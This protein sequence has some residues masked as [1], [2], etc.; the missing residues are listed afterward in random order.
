LSLLEFKPSAVKI[1]GSIR[2]S[3]ELAGTE[4]GEIKM[5]I[6]GVDES[7]HAEVEGDASFK[8]YS[9]WVPIEQLQEESETLFTVTPV[10][11]QP[12]SLLLF[13]PSSQSITLSLNKLEC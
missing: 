7:V 1:S 8:E 4:I 6:S 13:V 2:I 3:D 12:D 11:S 10:V 5:Q 9:V